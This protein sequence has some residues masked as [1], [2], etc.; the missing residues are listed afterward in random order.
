MQTGD[1]GKGA[2]TGRGKGGDGVVTGTIKSLKAQGGACARAVGTLSSQPLR[3][4]P[5]PP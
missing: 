2:R 4:A 5:C 3:R 1:K